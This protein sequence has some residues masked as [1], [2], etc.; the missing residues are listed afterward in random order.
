[1]GNMTRCPVTLFPFLFGISK[2][3]IYLQFLTK[4][5]LEQLFKELLFK[6]EPVILGYLSIFIFNKTF[7]AIHLLNGISLNQLRK[8]NIFIIYKTSTYI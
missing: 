6:I 2:K 8:Y 4:Q 5:H 1:M 3:D 7:I